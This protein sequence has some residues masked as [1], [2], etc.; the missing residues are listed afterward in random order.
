MDG[1]LRKSQKR[2]NADNYKQFNI[3]LKPELIEAFRAAC[4]KSSMSMRAVLVSFMTGYASAPHSS[5]KQESEHKYIKRNDRRKA[6]ASILVQLEAIRDSEMQ[7]MDNMPEVFRYRNTSGNSD[8]RN[9]PILLS[10]V[11]TNR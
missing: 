1:N 3:S 7:Y 9:I 11:S 8:K 2:W 5:Q 10:T 4:E 6:V